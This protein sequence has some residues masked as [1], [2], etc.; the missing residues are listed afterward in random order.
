[1]NTAKLITI[2]LWFLL[3]L[4]YLF[5][6]NVYLNYFALI[7]LVIHAIECVVFY[8]KL[9]SSEDGILLSIFKNMVF[10]VIY[11]NELKN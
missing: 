3:G 11:V 4:N 9:S 1:M 5:Y 6:G 8:K 2:L 10:G 7:L